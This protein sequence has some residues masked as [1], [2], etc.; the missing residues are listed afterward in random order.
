MEAPASVAAFYKSVRIRYDIGILPDK[1]LFSRWGKDTRPVQ[2]V[3][4]THYRADLSAG[5]NV[6]F[7]PNRYL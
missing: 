2:R 5:K 3:A 6:S 7:F 1:R 4:G